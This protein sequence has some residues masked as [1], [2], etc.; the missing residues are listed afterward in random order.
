MSTQHPSQLALTNQP[1]NESTA[2]I[3]A[4]NNTTLP[5]TT[6][7][8]NTTTW[9][10]TPT[11]TTKIADLFTHPTEQS[12]SESEETP[13]TTLTDFENKEH[14]P[15]ENTTDNTRENQPLSPISTYA[16][17]HKTEDSQPSELGDN[18]NWSKTT[19]DSTSKPG[20]TKNVVM[21]DEVT[22]EAC[23][24]CGSEISLEGTE[25]HCADCGLV[26]TDAQIDRGPEW[27]AFDSKQ[28]NER[29]RVGAPV[30][31]AIHDKGLSTMI[32]F[33]NK[34]ANGN[35]LSQ[36]QQR[37]FNR[38][39]KWDNR[40]KVKNTQERNLRQAFGE[41]QR[42]SSEL[43]LPD[44]VE[45]TAC[46]LYRRAHNE[47][48]LPGR[49]IE[50]MTSAAVY[51]A[52]RQTGI[53][54]TLEYLMTYSQVSEEKVTAA[55]RYVCRELEIEVKPPEV[56]EYLTRVCSELNVSSETQQ[57]AED[58]LQEGISD[59]VHSGKDPSGLAAS[60]VY[61]ATL[62]T[63]CDRVTQEQA[64]NVADVCELTIR[65]RERELLE[66]VG[67]DHSEVAPPTKEEVQ[68]NQSQSFTPSIDAQSQA[69]SSTMD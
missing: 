28:Q 15:V 62:L 67:V 21:G 50:A 5:H 19:S 7:T 64:S 68:A 26:V 22:T 23:P 20:H 4:N 3:P 33:D 24:D 66:S 63:R 60:A 14:P 54:K 8:T 18:A 58:L 25:H 41:I 51:I 40:F 12:T 27:R 46:T 13:D 6:S 65:E 1:T 10:H 45:E 44:Y 48:L 52:M 61:A 35:S 2:T 49:S 42:L 55:Y 39:R 59:N 38:L 31:E 30:N 17:Q 9:K 32:G 37:R 16:R 47:D 57:K 56:L 36:K 34:D 69:A 29:S 53:P 11:K 43:E